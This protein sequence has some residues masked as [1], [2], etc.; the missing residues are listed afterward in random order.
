MK[1][2]FRVNQKQI[3]LIHVAKADLIAKGVLDEGGYRDLLAQFKRQGKPVTSSKDLLQWQADELLAHFKK[4][5]WVYRPKVKKAPDPKKQQ[6]AKQI[7]LEAIQATLGAL[8][9]DLGLRR[10]HRQTDVPGG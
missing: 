9:K 7:H 3:G 5:G 1:P 4:C 8:V 2:H 10:R 6:R